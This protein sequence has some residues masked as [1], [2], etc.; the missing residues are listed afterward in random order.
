ME[1]LI[2]W[3]IIFLFYLFSAYR[4]RQKKV[5]TE[6][7]QVVEPSPQTENR[8]SRT[9]FNNIFEFLDEAME[10][11]ALNL[12]DDLASNI[13]QQSNDDLLIQHQSKQL[14]Q[15][16][17]NEVPDLNIV[18]KEDSTINIKD[19]HLDH[20]QSRINTNNVVTHSEQKLLTLQ[21]KLKNK[22]TKLAIVMQ[23][24]FD[25]PKSQGILMKLLIM[26]PPGAGKGT[27]AKILAQKFNLVH[28]STGDILR[29]E[30]DRNSEVGLKAQ[31]YM[32]AGNLVP[33]EVLLEMMNS[34]LTE[35][36]DN[37]VILDGFP[38]TIP[39]A[40]GLSKIFQSLNQNIDAIINIEVDKDV[41]IRRLVE[42]AKNSGRADDTEEVIKNRQNVYLELTAPLIEF[43]HGNIINID[44][45]GSIDKVTERI[46]KRIP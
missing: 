1:E 34:T 2:Y 15:S 7:F 45:D 17:I 23:A 13:N 31:T 26:G 33:D 41:L 18:D 37:G 19:K 14:N 21:N 8:N 3:G 16:V 35:L 39:Q 20:L 22:P 27:Q 42:R 44:G 24:I 32:N 6:E 43:Y 5:E 25:P 4:S 29:K 10:K 9:D 28:L 12:D 40:D 30:I 46:L 11:S 38:R 36:K